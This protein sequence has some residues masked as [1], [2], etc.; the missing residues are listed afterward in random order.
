MYILLKNTISLSC[1][2]YKYRNE[3]LKVNYL[4]EV[5]RLSPK[6]CRGM[7]PVVRFVC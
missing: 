3:S 5:E 2:W 1:L 6:A 7:M 4:L